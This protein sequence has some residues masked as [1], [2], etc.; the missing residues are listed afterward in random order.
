MARENC[1]PGLPQSGGVILGDV[2]LSYA[3]ISDNYWYGTT[4]AQQGIWVLDRIERLRP[5]YVFPSVME[6]AGS[7]DHSLM[8]SAIGRV[9]G[10]HAALRSRFRLNVRRHRVEYC[11]DG[12]HPAV[13]FWAVGHH[14]P[15]E[16]LNRRIEE[17]CY[18][19]FDLAAGPPARAD[20]IRVDAKTTIL[21]LTAH[22]IVFDGWSRRLVLTE[23][24]NTYQAAL[25]GREPELAGPVHPAEVLAAVSKQEVAA[26]IKAVAERLRGAPT[27]VALPYDRTPVDDS[28]LVSAVA[29]TGFDAELTRALMATATRAGCTAFVL[30]VAIVA[31]TLARAGKQKDFLFA[32][33]WPGRDDPG[34]HDVVGMFMNTVVLRVSLAEHTTWRELLRDARIG[35]HEAFINADVPLSAIASELGKD[36]VS[37]QPLTPVMINCAD[38]PTPFE[39]APG[40]RGRW[41]PLGVMYSKWDLTVFVHLDK[42][43]HDKRLKLSLDYPAQLFDRTTMSDLLT[44]LR[45]SATDLINHPEEPVLERSTQLDLSDASVRLELVRSAWREILGIDEIDDETGFFEAG[46]DSLLLVALVEQLSKVS[47]CVLKTMDVFRAASIGGQ[48]ALLDRQ[49]TRA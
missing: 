27:G 7:I 24:A 19:P 46:G 11:T 34:A 6:F 49:A 26:Q 17:F 20:V 25:L 38:V 39:L 37:G 40:V 12:A 44:A 14:W 32:V 41:R 33:V 43:A 1:I 15:C 21:V 3:A 31:A 2:I 45:R 4:P 47:G 28:P 36:G 18:T 48:A 8:V 29:A 5:A 13:R 9:L 23:I 35:A 30:A 10:R 16:E 42:G 22:H